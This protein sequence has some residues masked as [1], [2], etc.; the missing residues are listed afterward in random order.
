MRSTI[1]DLTELAYTLSEIFGV[2]SDL[3]VERATHVLS[4]VKKVSRNEGKT[5]DVTPEVFVHDWN[6][7]RA[8]FFGPTPVIPLEESLYKPWTTRE[9]HPLKGAKGMVW[10][11]P[12]IHIQETLSS[13]GIDFDSTRSS[14]PDHLAVILEFVGFLLEAERFD[15]V[16]PFSK[17]HLDWLDF[18]LN[19][20]VDRNLPRGA[21]E[22]IEAAIALREVIISLN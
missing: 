2:D 20:V 22:P 3:D 6:L 13:F 11:D 10:G 9:G 19:L 21:K 8:I 4:L 14:S 1:I 12:A 18:V 16:A 7:S 15:V 5:V 17:D